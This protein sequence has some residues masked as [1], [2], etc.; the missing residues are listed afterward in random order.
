MAA[1][2]AVASPSQQAPVEW[3]VAELDSQIRDLVTKEKSFNDVSNSATLLC[4]VALATTRMVPPDP[5]VQQLTGCEVLGSDM[6]AQLGAP[7]V[8][9]GKAEANGGVDHGACREPQEDGATA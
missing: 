3:N 5:G 6:L 8:A 9:S 7:A 2:D 1:A 4:L